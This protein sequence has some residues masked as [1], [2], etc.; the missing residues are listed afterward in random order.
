[1][2]AKT[3]LVLRN[4]YGRELSRQSF[5]DSAQANRVMIARNRA[6]IECKTAWRWGIETEHEVVECRVVSRERQPSG[7][8]L[9]T[10]ECGHTNA[11]ARIHHSE[12]VPCLTCSNLAQQIPK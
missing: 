6:E 7:S 10:L 4:E 11:T 3:T 2:S 1:M 9:E 8:F 12:R 5:T